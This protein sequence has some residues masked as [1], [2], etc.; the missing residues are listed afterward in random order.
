[1]A[2]W[3]RHARADE[4]GNGYF[5]FINTGVKFGDDGIEGLLHH[6]PIAQTEWLHDGTANHT[7]S[8]QLD[9]G[10]SRIMTRITAGAGGAITSR[11][12]KNLVLPRDFGTFEPYG[13]Q[14]LVRGS[15]PLPTAYTVTVKRN[16]SPDTTVN[17]HTINPS[18]HSVFE[19]MQLPITDFVYLAQDLLLVEVKL[20]TANNGEWAEIG[21]MQ[22]TYI[23]AG[24]NI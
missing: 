20:T 23:S 16:G 11:M 6:V 1:M 5:R 15:N 18:V 3:L 13:F 24:G 8:D 21:H 9:A 17:D 2:Q 12:R 19:V 22:L 7:K 4:I 10:T 14:M